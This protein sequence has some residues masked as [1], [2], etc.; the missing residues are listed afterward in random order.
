MWRLEGLGKW[1]LRARPPETIGGPSLRVTR[2]PSAGSAVCV[3][4]R[5][6]K[7][8]DILNRM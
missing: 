7:K 1:H 3:A 4:S 6:N 2:P 5:L 8:I